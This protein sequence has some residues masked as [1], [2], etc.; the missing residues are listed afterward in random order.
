MNKIEAMLNDLVRGNKEAAA[1]QFNAIFSEK[2]ANALE[3]YKAQVGQNFF[4]QKT[5]ES[6]EGKVFR[7]VPNPAAKDKVKKV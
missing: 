1:E 4:P 5:N 6:V 3:T 7:V 2:A